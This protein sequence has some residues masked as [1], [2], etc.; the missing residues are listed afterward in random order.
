MK[1]AALAAVFLLDLERTPRRKIE[2]VSISKRNGRG[3]VAG[4]SCSNRAIGR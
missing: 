2:P 4:A 1:T 3:D